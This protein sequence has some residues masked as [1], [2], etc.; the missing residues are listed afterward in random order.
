MV[1]AARSIATGFFALVAAAVLAVSG[2]SLADPTAA[3]AASPTS[4]EVTAGPKDPQLVEYRLGSS[5]KVRVIVYGE[6]S[7]S[8]EFFISGNGKASLPLIGDIQAA[9]LTVRAFQQ[10]VQAALKDGYL[11]DPRVSVE[12]LTYRPYYIMGEV[13]KPGQY[14]YTSDLTVMNAVATAGGFTYRANKSRVYVKHIGDEKERVYPLTSTAPVSPGDTIRI[15]ER[16][17]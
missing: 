7:L 11:K 15:G 8:G 10:E 9:G 4:E 16:L 1:Q 5:D 3:P 17:F 2:P 12:V 14:P 13:D 6:E